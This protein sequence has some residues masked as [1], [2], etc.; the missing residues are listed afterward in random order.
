[1]V[2]TSQ[3]SFIVDTLN[4]IMCGGL[5]YM[6]QA[7]QNGKELRQY[8]QMVIFST[9]HFTSSSRKQMNEPE[10][11]QVSTSG[12]S[13]SSTLKAALQELR[14]KG[15]AISLFSGLS[16]STM[17]DPPDPSQLDKSSE[18]PKRLEG[19]KTHD[20]SQVG[21]SEDDQAGPDPATS[22]GSRHI[23]LGRCVGMLILDKMR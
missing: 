6:Q 19:A 13:K 3:L 7:R 11:P 5:Q 10:K 16:V 17:S 12:G 21:T 4:R 20:A 18:D 22:V 8:L 1:M 15:S 23:S 2:T 9:L 14:R